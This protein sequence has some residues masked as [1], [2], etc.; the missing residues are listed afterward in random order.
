MSLRIPPLLEP[1]LSLP[2]D[3]AL[4][5][6]TSVLGAS[7]NW[8]VL[9]YLYT[10]LRGATTDDAEGGEAEP[11]GVVLV[12]FMRDGAFWREGA[13]KLVSF[14]ISLF[15]L[16]IEVADTCAGPGP[17]LHEQKGPVCLRRRA[18]GPVCR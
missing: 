2:A 10:Y 8:L 18:D 6:A 1:Y 7:S 4:V 15:V 13:S 3:S 11:L 5:L 12:S 16:V 17:R 14:P 9:R